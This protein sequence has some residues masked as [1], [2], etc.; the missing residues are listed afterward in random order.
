[1]SCT[2]ANGN[3]QDD[4]QHIDILIGAKGGASSLLSIDP[5]KM[6]FVS[7]RNIDISDINYVRAVNGHGIFALSEGELSVYDR[8]RLQNGVVKKLAQTQTKSSPTAVEASRNGDMVFSAHFS[9][10][11]LSARAFD[12]LKFSA[13]QNFEC[14]WAHQ[15]R[16]HPN[17]KWA[18]AACMKN[19][20]RQFNIMPNTL[21]VSPMD[22]AKID[23]K[24][25]PRHMEFHPNGKVIYV[26]LQV[27]SQI[28]V[29]NINP[30]TGQVITPA[31]Q[32]INTTANGS[33]NKSSDLH[34]T[35]DGKWLFAFN[36]C[37][38]NM[39]AFQVKNEGQLVYQ[40]A[41]PMLY[42]EVRDWAMSPDGKYIITASDQ[43]HVGLWGIN[44]VNGALKLHDLSNGHGHA[45]TATLLEQ[46]AK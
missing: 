27:S 46:N 22:V 40:G 45:I 21:A 34:I 16:P 11:T 32:L 33:K 42:G 7:R 12:G 25:G 18:Y 5:N 38:Q 14:G 31:A 9:N 37:D 1:M 20:L 19:T 8:H 6:K 36:R 17:G 43:G 39:A 26:L 29:F 23:I 10:N 41:T 2:V 13:P 15:F 30:D 44:P 28:A 3:S 4:V 24:G 35:P